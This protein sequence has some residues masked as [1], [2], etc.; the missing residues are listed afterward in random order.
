MRI[1]WWVVTSVLLGLALRSLAGPPPALPTPDRIEGQDWIS[2]T[3]VSEKRESGHPW[4]KDTRIFGYRG[5]FVTL[6]EVSH[7]PHVELTLDSN[8][9]YRLGFLRDGVFVGGGTIWRRPYPGGLAT[10]WADVPADVQRGG[11]DTLHLLPFEGDGSFSL[12][13]V[14]LLEF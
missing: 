13:H 1:L 12:G 10:Y 3:F 14:R 6:G 11:F 4:N 5:L 9:D 2:A 7:V 8:D